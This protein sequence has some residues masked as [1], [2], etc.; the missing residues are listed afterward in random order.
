MVPQKAL[1]RPFLFVRDWEG[2]G[3]RRIDLEN[4]DCGNCGT[5]FVSSFSENFIRSLS[6]FFIVFLVTKKESLLKA[7]LDSA[8][9]AWFLKSFDLPSYGTESRKT[10][11]PRLFSMCRRD[12][13]R[14]KILKFFYWGE[15]GQTNYL[16]EELA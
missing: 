8:F 13:G 10:H 1:S 14:E 7:R 4:G 11:T 12:E 16:M 3:L 5:F 15:G 2:K 9:I 6:A